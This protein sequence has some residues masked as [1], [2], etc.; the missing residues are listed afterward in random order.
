MTVA[1]RLGWCVGWCMSLTSCHST[2][3]RCRRGQRGVS[4]DFILDTGSTVNVLNPMV[5]QE[6][7]LP[8]V[9][10][11]VGFASRQACTSSGQY[12]CGLSPASRA[13][14]TQYAATIQHRTWHTFCHCQADGP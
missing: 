14:S 5:A 8:V 1:E 3:C 12:R 13:D 9:G 4:L 7:A 6:L 11:Q 10:M 2:G